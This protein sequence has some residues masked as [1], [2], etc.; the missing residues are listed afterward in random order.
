MFRKKMMDIADAE[1]KM[2]RIYHVKMQMIPVSEDI[3]E[4]KE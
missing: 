4:N 1:P 2:N 3:D